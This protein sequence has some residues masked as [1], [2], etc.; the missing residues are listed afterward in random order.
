MNLD[1]SWRSELRKLL[2]LLLGSLAVGW[3]LGFPLEALAVGLGLVSLVWLLQIWRMRRWLE[4]PDQLPPESSGLWGVIYSTIYRLQRENREARLRLQSTVDYL[5]ESFASMRDG[6]VILTHRGAIEWSNTAA[7]RLL[8]L[9]YPRDRGQL[10]LNLVRLPEF[11]DYFLARDFREPL[12]VRMKGGRVRHL[13]ME[14]T[15]FA[16]GDFLLFVR[17]ITRLQE[18]EQMRRDFVGNVSHELRTPLTVFKGYLDTMLDNSDHIDARF[19]RPLQ[20]MELQ[21]RRMESLLHDLLWLSRIESERSQKKTVK[22]DMVSLLE[23]LH[24]ELSQSHPQRAVALEIESQEAVY[25][26][27]Q[28]LHSAV[29]NLVL[30]AIKYSPDDTVVKVRW[31]GDGE[32]V[33]LA[34]IDHGVGIQE[35][36]IPRLTERFYR[37]DESRSSQTGGTGLGL[38]IVKHVAASHGATLNIQSQPGKGSTFS[39]SFSAY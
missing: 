37:V 17:D 39:L 31:A 5:Q 11:H 26:D 6:V 1:R 28:E 2:S 32:T 3:V 38:A 13:Q 21:I 7:H 12:L 22:I 15:P 25:G 4:H 34:V 8:Q 23:E 33:T 16:D 29:S 24:E 20:Q 36:H 30:N 9:E 35:E 19:H 10:I 14:I 18:T 27:Y